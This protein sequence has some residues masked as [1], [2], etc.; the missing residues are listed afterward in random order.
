MEPSKIVSTTVRGK[1]MLT[2]GA[3]TQG[4]CMH[5]LGRWALRLD[6]ACVV[7]MGA[8]HSLS[9]DLLG[10]FKRPRSDEY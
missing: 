8:I 7:A 4:S 6:G 9:A 3:P 1:V 10:T 2:F 5:N